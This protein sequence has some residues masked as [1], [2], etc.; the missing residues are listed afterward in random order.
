MNVKGRQEWDKWTQTRHHET[1]SKNAIAETETKHEFKS[2]NSHKSGKFSTRKNIR[3]IIIFYIF[4]DNLPDAFFTF[5][6][7]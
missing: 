5:L 6:F 3:T 7:S 2:G 1:I 4:S